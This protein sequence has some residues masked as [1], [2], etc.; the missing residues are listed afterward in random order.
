MVAL[1]GA[2]E[3]PVA[4]S[5]GHP[6][7]VSNLRKLTFQYDYLGRRVG[8]KAYNWAGTDWATSVAEDRKFVWHGWKLLAEYDCAGGRVLARNVTL[9]TASGR[10]IPDL[11]YRNSQ[12]MLRFMEV[13]NGR[14]ARL[15]ANQA[16]LFPEIERGG[17]IPRVARAAEA[18]LRVG[19]PLPPTPWISSTIDKRCAVRDSRLVRQVLASADR[20]FSSTGYQRRQRGIFTIGIA[21]AAFG[22]VGLN[23]ASASGAMELNVVVG[24]RIEAIEQLVCALNG[25]KLHPY[26]PP[27]LSTHIGYLMPS[28]GYKPW[29]V[30]DEAGCEDVVREI[31][32]AVQKYGLPFMKEHATVDET[33]AALR[34]GEYGFVG[35]REF[36]MIAAAILMGQKVDAESILEETL[37][38][39]QGRSD[40][41]AEALRRY[42]CAAQAA[43]LRGPAA[44]D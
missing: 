18:G 2:A 12:G 14:C 27:T 26:I 41:A 21:E 9:E 36:P 31:V 42:V 28:R 5:E 24:V 29:Y 13:K 4:A 39:V 33:F 43:I 37:S 32:A 19:E 25:E 11:A 6:A 38:S 1:V 34:S 44:L 8:K 22:W 7:K 10:T 30:T 16:K 3:Q 20:L 35:Q 23:R 17:A 15:R 40:P